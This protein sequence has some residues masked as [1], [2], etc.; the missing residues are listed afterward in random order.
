MALRHEVARLLTGG[1]ITKNEMKTLL[2][3]GVGAIV[4]G[5]LGAIFLPVHLRVENR[6]D[7]W[8]GRSASLCN[9]LPMRRGLI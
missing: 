5:V 3:V 2:A 4:A 7:N 8:R 1:Y 9:G 6:G